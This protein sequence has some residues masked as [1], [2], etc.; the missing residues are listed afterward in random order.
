MPL[1]GCTKPAGRTLA[2][3]QKLKLFFLWGQQDGRNGAGLAHGACLAYRVHGRRRPPGRPG[4]LAE[5]IVPARAWIFDSLS[6]KVGAVRGQAK[7]AADGPPACYI[8]RVV[9]T[10]A[11]T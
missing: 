7:T 8:E 10:I 5:A 1:I 9:P 4:V 3:S 6:L 11:G 2:S